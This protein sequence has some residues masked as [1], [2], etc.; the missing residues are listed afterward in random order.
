MSLALALQSPYK[1][2]LRA[3]LY[4]YDGLS[5]SSEELSCFALIYL[6]VSR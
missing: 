1:E 5:Y 2:P 6:G 4:M 3:E